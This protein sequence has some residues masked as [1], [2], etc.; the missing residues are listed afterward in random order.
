MLELEQYVPKENWYVS[1]LFEEGYWTFQ[2]IRKQQTTRYAPYWFDSTVAIAAAGTS[3]W[4]APTDANGRFYL[5]PTEEEIVYQFFT[6][7]TPSQSKLYL[8]YTQREDRMNLITPRAVP[9]P[10][11]YWDGELSPYRNPSPMTELWTVHDIYPYFDAENV[12]MT[13]ASAFVG[14]SFYVTPFTYKVLPGRKPEDRAKIFRFLRGERP[15][16]VRTMGDGDRPIKCPYW[17]LS[18]YSHDMIQP[19]EV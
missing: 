19:E 7:I 2:V 15:C 8:Q 6:G 17:L 12:A 11:G 3:G 10:I 4:E 14:A 1:L 5:E 18:T 13:G 9:G 16:T